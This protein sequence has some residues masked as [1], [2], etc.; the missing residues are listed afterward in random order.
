MRA[1]ATKH[2]P[3]GTGAQEMLHPPDAR[4]SIYTNATMHADP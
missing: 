1:D 4:L 3:P 2:V